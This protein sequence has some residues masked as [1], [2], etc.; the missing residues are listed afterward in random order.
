MDY[1]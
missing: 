1:H